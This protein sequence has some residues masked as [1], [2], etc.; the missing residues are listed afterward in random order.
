MRKVSRRADK[1]A[2]LVAHLL[3]VV[4]TGV[5]EWIFEREPSLV[6]GW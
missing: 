5:G 2:S 1:R 3:R 4:V 6:M